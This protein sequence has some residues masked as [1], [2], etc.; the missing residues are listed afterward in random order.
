MAVTHSL[1][2]VSVWSIGLEQRVHEVILPKIFKWY[3]DDFGFS[4]QVLAAPQPQLQP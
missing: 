4:K 2:R 1:V 3:K